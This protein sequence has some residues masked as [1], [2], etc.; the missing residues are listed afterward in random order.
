[1][2]C[3]RCE[4]DYFGGSICAQCG[5]ALGKGDVRFSRMGQP[6]FLVGGAPMGATASRLPVARGEEEPG[7]ADGLPA[8]LGRKIVES[9][10]ACALFSVALRFGAFML[11]VVD[12]LTATGGDVRS[13]ISLLAEMKKEI[14]GYD[15]FF[16]AL[17]TVLIFRFRHNPR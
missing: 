3:K 16:W 17:I 14:G 10:F 6:L 15:V 13:G 4:T 2:Y 1:M 12:S 5:G 7:G 11:K 9:A 8:R